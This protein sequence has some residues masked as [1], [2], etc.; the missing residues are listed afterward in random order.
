MTA[1]SASS[2]GVSRRLRLGALSVCARTQSDGVQGGERREKERTPAALTTANLLTDDAGL[3]ASGEGQRRIV[4]TEAV[5]HRAPRGPAVPAPAGRSSP[6]RGLRN[7]CPIEGRCRASTTTRQRWELEYDLERRG[8]AYVLTF[9]RE[10]V[11]PR[12]RRL[13]A[14][15][16][17]STFRGEGLIATRPAFMKT[18]EY[19]RLAGGHP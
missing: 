2:H 4:Q 13:L 16:Y 3:A 17:V 9:R 8:G 5:R 19:D 14:S 11:G 1:R 10:E 15:N 12:C 18:I 6:S 7:I